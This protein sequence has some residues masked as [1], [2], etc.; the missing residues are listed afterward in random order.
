[1]VA[2]V[3]VGLAVAQDKMVVEMVEQ[4]LPIM[5]LLVLLTQEAAEAVEVG[6]TQDKMVKQ[7]AQAL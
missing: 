5:Q 1:M 3:A 4:T 7:V 2:A 6:I